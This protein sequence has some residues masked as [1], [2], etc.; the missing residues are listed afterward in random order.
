MKTLHLLAAAA[1]TLS[2]A[3]AAHAEPGAANAC[4]PYGFLNATN[5][6]TNP[7]F[8]T[9][10]PNGSPVNWQNGQPAPA[11]AAAASWT[12][13]SSNAGAPITTA[14]EPTNVP[15]NGGA[16]MLHITSGSNEGGV[17]QNVANSPR[18]M[19]FS[20]WVKVRRGHVAIQAQGG[21]TGPVSWSTKTGEWEQLRVCTDGTVPTNMLVIYNQDPAG[22]DFWVDRAEARAIP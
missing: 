13:H 11:P 17:F 4:P 5:Y 22:G 3:G 9:L 8:E 21:N 16:R 14:L 18:K 6:A 10:G 7:S 1:L 2:A 15:Q 19:M 12:M 20:V